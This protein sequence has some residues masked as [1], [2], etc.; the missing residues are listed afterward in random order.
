MPTE[1][2]PLNKSEAATLRALLIRAD[3]A[4]QLSLGHRN[5]DG[6]GMTTV[7]VSPAEVVVFDAIDGE[8]V[9]EIGILHPCIAINETMLKTLRMMPAVL[10]GVPEHSAELRAVARVLL[11]AGDITNCNASLAD[12][13]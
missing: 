3:K 4:G 6:Y 5:A 11:D 10:R 2:H 1:T 7:H 13:L 8:S 9:Q 12:D